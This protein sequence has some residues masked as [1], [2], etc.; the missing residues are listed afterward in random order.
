[1]YLGVLAVFSWFGVVHSASP[2]GNVYL[3]WSLDGALERAVADQFALGYLTLAGVL[4]LLSLTKES[5]EAPPADLGHA[6]PA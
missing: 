5:R 1:M 3:P 2:D 6:G 4:L